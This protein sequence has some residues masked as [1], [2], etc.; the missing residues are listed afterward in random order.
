[1]GKIILLIGLTFFCLTA[2]KKIEKQSAP[3]K[4]NIVWIVCEDM[5][6]H[7]GSYGDKLTKTPNLDLLAAEGLRYTN[8][9]TTAGV[10]APSRNAIITGRYQTANGG[11]HMR[12]TA[13]SKLA[14]EA[15]PDGFKP[16]STLLPADVQ[17]YPYYLRQE[18]YY[19][20]N[21]SK[22]DYQFESSPMMWDE[23]SNKAHWRNRKDK[24]QPFF[25]IFNLMVTHESQVWARDKEPL[26]VDP[27]NVEVP[28]YYPD[29]SISRKVI[30][31]FLTNVM[32]MDKQVGNIIQE[33]K[34]DGLY[35]NTIIFFYSDHGDGLPYVK[36]EL[37]HRGLRVPLIIKAPFLKGGSTDDHLISAIDFAPTLLSLA[38]IPIRKSMHGQAFL[39]KQK[40][41][42]NRTYIYGARDRMDSET[43]RVRS[44]SDGRF[45][46]LRYYMPKLPFYQNIRYRLQNPLM[47]HLLKLRDEGK[48]NA[49]QMQWF[50]STKPDEEL[51]DTQT[52]PFELNNLATDPQYATKLKELRTAHEKWLKDYTDLGTMPE[53][54]MVAQWWEG[55][56]FPPENTEPIIAF[57]GNKVTLK[58]KTNGTILGYRNSEKDSWTIYKKPF[59]CT[60]GDS[61]FVVAHRIG[62]NKPLFKNV[63]LSSSVIR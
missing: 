60:N 51:F 50:R 38:G 14:I 32:L 27:K 11:H 59:Y 26:L 12:T 13:A 1:M 29:D 7:L 2:F 37:H 30:A 19:C 9:F 42:K 39:G 24:S 21:N 3:L 8:A 17:P 5:S 25:S 63:H 46:Y 44:V 48:L 57:K 61:L 6:P 31:R 62:Y 53:M 40:S 56:E 36:R 54:E 33:L 58:S 16:Y 20:S 23:S 43:D 52:D 22:E 45:N 35:D 18:G 55:K 41:P 15:Y 4:P 34:D 10:C 28:P 47:P 49:D